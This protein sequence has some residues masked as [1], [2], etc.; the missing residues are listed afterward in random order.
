M[1][2]DTSRKTAL[3]WIGFFCYLIASYLVLCFMLLYGPLTASSGYPQ[4]L[5]A[6]IVLL[7]YAAL[8]LSLLSAIGFGI[9]LYN[10]YGLSLLRSLRE[11]RKLKHG[12]AWD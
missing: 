8:L 3:I 1:E 9:T 10:A 11:W 5:A 4:N 2:A 7:A 12:N 6:R